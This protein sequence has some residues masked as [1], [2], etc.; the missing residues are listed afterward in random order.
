[1]VKRFSMGSNGNNLILR[2]QSR[3]IGGVGSRQA[4][5]VKKFSTSSNSKEVLDNP[6]ILGSPMGSLLNLSKSRT[7]KFLV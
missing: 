6:S 4:R 7:V 3:R 1:M 2:A 5:T